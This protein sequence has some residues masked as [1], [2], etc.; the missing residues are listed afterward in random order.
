MVQR[1][2]EAW[3][4]NDEVDSVIKEKRKQWKKWPNGKDKETYLKAKRKAKSTVYAARK[5]CQEEKFG[6]LRSVEDK[7]DKSSAGPSDINVEMILA[8]GEDIN[9]AN[10]HLVIYVVANG[11]IPN[12]WSLSYIINCYKGKGD[13]LVR[14]NYRGLKLLDHV[15]KIMERFLPLDKAQQMPFLSSVR[16]TKSIWERKMT[17]SLRSFI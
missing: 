12:D 3:W 13:S 11:K 7:L 4:W 2:R 5:R 1:N 9:L 8:G 15:M 6:N 16:F 10:T 17:C 14:G